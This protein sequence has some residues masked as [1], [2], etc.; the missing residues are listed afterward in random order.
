[1]SSPESKRSSNSLALM[2]YLLSAGAAH[3]DDWPPVVPA[4]KQPFR[5]W[6]LFLSPYNPLGCIEELI[7]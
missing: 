5:A 1:M 6:F 2:V 4:C 7:I 3:G